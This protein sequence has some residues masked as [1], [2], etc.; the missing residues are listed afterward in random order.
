[1]HSACTQVVEGATGKGTLAQVGLEA[2]SGSLLLALAL[3]SGGA[4]VAG[5]VITVQKILTRKMSRT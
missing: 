3:L 2:P 5:S 1:M 4:T